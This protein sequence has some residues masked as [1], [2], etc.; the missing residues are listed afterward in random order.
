MK[1]SLYWPYPLVYDNCKSVLG[2]KG[3]R[4]YSK[5]NSI[6]YFMLLFRYWNSVWAKRGVV[7]AKKGLDIIP[8]GIVSII[9]CYYSGIGTFGA[10]KGLDIIPSGIV[11][12][13]Y[14][15]IPNFKSVDPSFGAK[16]GLDI[17]PISGYYS[18]FELYLYAKKQTKK[19]TQA[20]LYIYI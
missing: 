14:V 5:W 9:S 8:S 17:I 3:V 15:I 6:H 20:S 12:I 1:S 13:I 18:T 19:N 11:S 7:V 2:Q 16:K 10:K 4:Y